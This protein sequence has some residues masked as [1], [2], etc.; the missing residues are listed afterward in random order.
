MAEGAGQPSLA[1][2]GLAGEDDLF[3]GLD[4][5]ALC[6]REDLPSI[7]PPAGG[8]VDIFDAGV[9]KAHLRVTE[10]VGEAL[11]G[12]GC[13]FPVEHEPQPF[14]ALERLAWI[15]FG[16][17]LPGVCHACQAKRGH[18]VKCGVCQHLVLPSLGYW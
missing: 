7:E 16:Q 9:G 11:V 5:V 2:A 6:Q 15:L 12:P 4:P 8:E 18:L 13:G 14:I 10:P 17:C 1:G 3:L